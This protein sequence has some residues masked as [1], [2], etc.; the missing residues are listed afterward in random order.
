VSILTRLIDRLLGRP[1]AGAAPLGAPDADLIPPSS[2]DDGLSLTLAQMATET[3]TK[4]SGRV[5]VITLAHLRHAMGDE[6]VRLRERVVLIAES[7][8][9][10]MIG[11]GN[12]YIPQDEDSWLLLM[13]SLSEP[14]AEDRANDIARTLG[15]KLIGERFIEREPPLPQAAKVDLSLALRADGSLDLEA[16]KASARQARLALA[17]RD[18]RRPAEILA[19]AAAERIPAAATGWRR[20]STTPPSA[21]SSRP[22]WPILPRWGKADCAPS[23]SCRFL[24]TPPAGAS[25]HRCSAPSRPCRSASA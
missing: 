17:A 23:T 11:K 4:A 14:E 8:I 7:T 18:V 25:R 20:P 3:T 24:T 22:R 9:G 1:E 16:L 10:R 13:P 12:N 21:T 2:W 15:Q 5:Q 19:E 6:W